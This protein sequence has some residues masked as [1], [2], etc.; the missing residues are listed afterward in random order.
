MQ[1]SAL[2]I[3]SVVCSHVFQTSE[4]LLKGLFW[5]TTGRWLLRL[6][7]QVWRISRIGSVHWGLWRVRGHSW[8]THAWSTHSWST[9]AWSTHAWC[10]I[11]TWV[12]I[13]RWHASH[14]AGR[15]HVGWHTRGRSA[16]RWPLVVCNGIEVNHLRL[17]CVY[18]NWTIDTTDTLGR[19]DT[20][21]EAVR[22]QARAGLVSGRV[23]DVSLLGEVD[24]AKDDFSILGLPEVYVLSNYRVEKIVISVTL[25]DEF[26]CED[27]CQLLSNREQLLHVNLWRSVNDCRESI[28]HIFWRSMLIQLQVR[29]DCHITA[30]IHHLL[31]S[32][33]RSDDLWLL[34]FETYPNF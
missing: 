20:L 21:P 6:L 27:R 34:Y 11:H 9:H 2:T 29:L 10:H 31:D 4:T 25:S 30:R 1:F 33:S 14:T 23:V 32:R 28:V 22:V 8:R 3:K 7:R 26:R 12:S 24:H 15:R 13:G 5:S 16:R 17:G 19:W 18:R